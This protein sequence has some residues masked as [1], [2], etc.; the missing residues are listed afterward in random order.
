MVCGKIGR[1]GRVGSEIEFGI[2]WRDCSKNCFYR[3]Q[4]E[5]CDLF[6]FCFEVINAN[7]LTKLIK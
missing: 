2:K 5:A 6:F 7:N 4:R 1:L 3:L